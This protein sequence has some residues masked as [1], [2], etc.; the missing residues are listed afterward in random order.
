MALKHADPDVV[1][2]NATGSFFAYPSNESSFDSIFLERTE[3]GH[4]FGKNDLLT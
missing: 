4:F 1:C 3:I 2:D